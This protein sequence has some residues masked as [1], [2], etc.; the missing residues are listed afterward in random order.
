MAKQALEGLKVLDLSMNLPGPLATLYLAEMGAEVVKVENPKTGGD[1]VRMAFM[2]SD[3]DSARF[4]SLNRGKKS[5]T[6]NLK[7]ADGQAAFKKLLS[8]YDVLVEG[9]RPGVMTAFGLD[10]DSLKGE[11]PGLIYVSIS[12]FGQDGPN[13]LRAG[14]DIGYCSMAGAMLISGD[15][16]TGRPSMPGMQVADVGGG[17][18]SAIM[19]LL[20][21]LFRRERTGRGGFV[22]VAMTDGVFSFAFMSMAGALLP[23]VEEGKVGKGLLSG[24][25]PCYRLYETADGRWV[26]LGA[27]EPHFWV[28]FCRSSDREDL[29]A[30]QFDPTAIDEVKAVFAARP[31]SLWQKQALEV[32]CCMEPLLTVEEAIDSEHNRH[33]PTVM[34]VKEDD[35]QDG[36]RV[37][38]PLRMSGFEVPQTRVAPKLG[39][40]TRQVLKQAGYSDDDIDAFSS[41][42]VI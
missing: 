24:L 41:G 40:H 22:D 35:G 7:S 27:L 42:G 3:G 20:A 19:G 34:R 13:R 26:G 21:A 37:L 16:D 36:L 28:N 6:L 39:E 4:K 8:Q 18:M 5:I 23:G 31:F 30:R 10:Y 15:P 38:T 32:D 9:F 12:G 29:L 33:R 2:G 11:Y 1:T 17:S 25:F 14:H